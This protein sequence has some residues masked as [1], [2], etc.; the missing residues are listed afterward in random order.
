MHLLV[1]E[2][3]W[4]PTLPKWIYGCYRPQILVVPVTRAVFR[5]CQLSGTN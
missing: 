1:G 2:H 3:L 5:G 4:L